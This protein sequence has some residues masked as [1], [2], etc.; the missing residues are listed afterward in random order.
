MAYAVVRLDNMAGTYDPTKQRSAYF[1][2]SSDDPAAIEN[3]NVVA[4]GALVTGKREIF[5]ASTPAAS[6]AIGTIGLVASV[7][8]L[9]DKREKNLDEYTNAAGVA[10]RVYFATVR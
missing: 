7:E 1:Y 5:A 10:L 8:K 2:D 4:L 3:G 6:S 9:Y